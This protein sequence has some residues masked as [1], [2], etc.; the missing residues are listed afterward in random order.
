MGEERERENITGFLERETT[1]THP[2]SRPSGS[3]EEA[4]PPAGGLK[5]KK[6]SCD[7]ERG[8][9]G[10]LVELRTP[11]RGVVVNVF[12]RGGYRGIRRYEINAERLLLLGS[13]LL[14]RRLL[15]RGGLLL[16]LAAR[17]KI[18]RV[19]SGKPINGDGLTVGRIGAAFF[20]GEQSASSVGGKRGDFKIAVLERLDGGN[21]HQC[22]RESW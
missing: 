12:T 9:A 21:C 20:F 14:L 2:N 11:R 16:L 22:R 13:S 17:S 15:L 7:D 4:P 10:H 3:Q 19:R 5:Q 8:G 1:N 6:I 18:A